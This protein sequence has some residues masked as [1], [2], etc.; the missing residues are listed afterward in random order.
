VGRRIQATGFYLCGWLSLVLAVLKVTLGVHCSWWRVLLP[1][2][3]FLGH[4]GLCVA[5]GL[6]WLSWIGS[7]EESEGLRIRGTHRLDGYQI[8]GMLCLLVSLDNLLRRI[9]GA[10]ESEW[11]WLA[12]GKMEVI[13]VSGILSLACQLRFW[14]GIVRQ[15]SSG[16]RR[17]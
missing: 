10:A 14:S 17:R 3:V 12:S 4:P 6:T 16:F 9:G 7:G 8:V 1:I 13:L 5:V 11:W 15:D 2:R